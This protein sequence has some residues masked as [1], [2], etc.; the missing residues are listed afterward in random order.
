MVSV[1]VAHKIQRNTFIAIVTTIISLLGCILLAVIPGTPKL[2]GLYLSWA[3]TG[4]GALVL[5][6]VSNNVSGYTKKVFYNAVLIVGQTFG[7]FIGPLIMVDSQAPTYSG[8]IIG[9]CLAN[10][11]VVV[12]LII[13]Y[14]IMKIENNCRLANPPETETDV[15][16]DL[17]DKQDKNFIYKL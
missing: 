12:L 8:G 9:F 15:Y 7:N 11:L 16:L 5:T 4:T 3:T 13:L 10:A 14:V 1:L 2:F 6:L 17:T